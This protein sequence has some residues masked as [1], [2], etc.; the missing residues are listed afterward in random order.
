ME[1]LFQNRFRSYIYENE[2]DK[3]TI[4][5]ATYNI[6]IAVGF[7]HSSGVCELMTNSCGVDLG[8]TLE[9]AWNCVEKL[10]RTAAIVQ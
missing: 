4:E 1:Q 5:E 7:F 10:R 9:K 8:E 6:Q 3:W 2:D